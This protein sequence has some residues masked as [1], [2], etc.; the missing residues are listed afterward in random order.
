LPPTVPTASLEEARKWLRI[1]DSAIRA[2]DWAGFGRAFDALKQVIGTE[3]D[4][5][6]R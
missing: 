6:A 4:T 1:A 5:V 3:R 2:G